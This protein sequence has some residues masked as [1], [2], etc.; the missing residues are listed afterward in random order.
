MKTS[1][2]RGWNTRDLR[3]MRWIAEQGGVVDRTTLGALLGHFSTSDV[4]RAR[5]SDASTVNSSGVDR[6]VHRHDEFLQSIPF[7][8]RMAGPT[9]VVLTSD[10]Y[11]KMGLVPVEMERIFHEE[12]RNA[13][14]GVGRLNND[15]Q[16]ALEA[17][18]NAQE[19]EWVVVET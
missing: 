18:L 17:L 19:N 1:S 16:D 11:V 15:Q 4:H 2:T 5:M 7:A 6:W 10:A 13:L 3:V 14:N 9:I 8:G 12:L